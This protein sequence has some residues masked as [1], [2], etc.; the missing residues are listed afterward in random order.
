MRILLNKKNGELRIYV[1]L[2]LGAL[3]DATVSSSMQDQGVV[4]YKNQARETVRIFFTLFPFGLN[5]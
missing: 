1:V 4:W 3:L 2:F 5:H